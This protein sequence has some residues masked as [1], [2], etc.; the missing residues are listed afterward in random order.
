MTQHIDCQSTSRQFTKYDENC[1][2]AQLEDDEFTN[3]IL[4]KVFRNIDLQ[5]GKKVQKY[6]Q[7]P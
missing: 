3:D 1:Y 5:K 2:Q 4:E 6:P 7:M